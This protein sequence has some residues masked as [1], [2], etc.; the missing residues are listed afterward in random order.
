MTSGGA[1]AAPAACNIIQGNSVASSKPA[2]IEF[3]NAT[4]GTVTVY[5]LDFFGARQQ[6]FTMQPGATVRQ[7]TYIGHAWL[8]TD[9]AG[10]CVGYVLSTQAAQRY[11]IGG[12]T[13]PTAP[14]NPTSTFTDPGGDGRSGGDVTSVAVS[15]DAA[16]TISFQVGV[17][18]KTANDDTVTLCL[19]TDRNA[20]TGL[21]NTTLCPLGAEYSLYLHY[22]GRWEV[23][24]FR[25]YTGPGLGNSDSPPR[26]TLSVAG[27]ARTLT[28]SINRSELGNT[29][30]F[31]F[32]LS[33]EPFPGDSAPDGGT[34]SYTLQTPAPPT[35]SP[36]PAPAAKPAAAN[37]R[38]VKLTT[39]PI[40]PIAGAA[41]TISVS[42]VLTTGATVPASS[43]RCRA[44]L[45]GAVLNGT[46][47]GECSLRIP[48]TAGGKKLVVSV[49]ASYR[50]KAKTRVA[51]F[52]VRPAKPA[53]AP[54]PS[55]GPSPSAG[56]SLGCKLA[57]VRFYGADSG[58][59][60][61]C[62]TLSASRKTMLEYAY[63]PCSEAK[64][65]L[66]AD[67]TA[68]AV[69]ITAAGTFS[70]TTSALAAGE[71]GI[72]FVNIT[73][74]GRIQGS[75]AAGTLTLTAPDGSSFRCSWSARA[76]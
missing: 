9:Q 58:K 12:G 74:S 11:V 28:V 50:G 67:R 42:I 8:V 19:D 73:F 34:W 48:A 36:K 15:N 76:G 38:S 59:A 55:S 21:Q 62:F 29:G 16:G 14:P 35:T 69:T 45:G 17:T 32:Q 31:A 33:T 41:F 26:S 54:K 23:S 56:S 22:F 7:G 60:P 24:S 13:G 44:T 63:R 64:T 1:G 40:A 37:I 65:A 71:A 18:T 4:G 2:T 53:T 5:W 3:V 6:W 57:G 68:K 27:D 75:T 10:T 30:S 51:T 66:S 52:T 20:G 47:R 61:V 49:S 46:G 25:H 43:A 39:R 70:S 72:G